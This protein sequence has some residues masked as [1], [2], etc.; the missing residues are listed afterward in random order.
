[1]ADTELVDI[2]DE[3]NNIVGVSDVA[4]AHEQRLRHRVAGFVVFI[5][6]PRQTGGKKIKA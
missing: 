4:T 5:C 3:Q 2:V 6:L 1:M